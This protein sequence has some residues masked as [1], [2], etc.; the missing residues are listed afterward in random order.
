MDAIKL[1]GDILEANATGG[2]VLG[3]LLQ[4]AGSGDAL[5]G[6]IALFAP[7]TVASGLR[8]ETDPADGLLTTLA[9]GG[10]PPV[11]PASDNEAVLLAQALCNAAKA[12]GQLTPEARAVIVGRMPDIESDAAGFLDAEL[13]S[14]LDVREFASRVPENLAHQVYAF[15]M[16]GMPVGSRQQ[17]QY[18]SAVAQGL[19]VDWI[20]AKKIHVEL[21]G[22]SIFG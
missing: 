9:S 6:V 21:G 12:D 5:G 22:P 7:G 17:V 11:S 18:L 16:M 8:Q 10:A 20:A 1:L 3:E 19:G 2:Q 13:S 14:A 15:S 4:R